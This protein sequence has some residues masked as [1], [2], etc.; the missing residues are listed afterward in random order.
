ML[1][2]NTGSQEFSDSE[3]RLQKFA[4]SFQNLTY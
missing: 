1:D 4:L 2:T 3:V